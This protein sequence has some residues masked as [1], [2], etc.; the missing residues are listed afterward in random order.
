[1]STAAFGMLLAHTYRMIAVTVA[2][3]GFLT[4]LPMKCGKMSFRTL[5]EASSAT[6]AKALGADDRL[7]A[8]LMGHRD[9]RSVEKYAKLDSSAI[10]AGLDR[11]SK[12]GRDNE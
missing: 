4:H 5:G 7:L 11:L 1:M 6:K 10:R 12:R 8:Q 2:K 9:T 3:S